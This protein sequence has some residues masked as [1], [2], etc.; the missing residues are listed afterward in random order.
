MEMN[1][2][3]IHLHWPL[4]SPCCSLDPPE[5][6]DG[7]Q[8]LPR[9]LSVDVVDLSLQLED[10]LGLD[11]DVCGLALETRPLSGQVVHLMR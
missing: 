6:T 1:A 8:R 5:P 4:L 3:V 9:V 11:G 10:L 7:F 2:L